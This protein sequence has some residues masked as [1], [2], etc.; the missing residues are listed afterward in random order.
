MNTPEVANEHKLK[1][2][3]VRRQDYVICFEEHIERGTFIH[4]DVSK[5]TKETALSLAIDFTR[6]S[7][8]HGG[9]IHAL[10]DSRDR[11]HEKFLKFYGFTKHEELGDHQEIWIWR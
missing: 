3:V 1:V 2:P 6:L 4:C 7:R 8:L 11:K 5:W 9:P 10:H